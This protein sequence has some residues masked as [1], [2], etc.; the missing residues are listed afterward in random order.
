MSHSK[1]EKM[2]IGLRMYFMK[3]CS[4]LRNQQPDTRI[5]R[6]R[7]G[8]IACVLR[9]GTPNKPRPALASGDHVGRGKTGFDEVEIDSRGE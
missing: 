6:P 4:Q 2:S 8:A 7:V 9:N 3:S 1:W 5:V